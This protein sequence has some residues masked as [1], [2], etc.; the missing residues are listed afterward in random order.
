MAG[1]K[2]RAVNAEQKEQ[3]RL[4]ILESARS[5]F[6][7][8]TD[9]ASLVMKQIAENIGLT[10]GTLYLYFRTKE[11]VFLALYTQ[12]FNRLFDS[13]DEQI[14]QYIGNN[15]DDQERN[16][17]EIFLKIMTQCVMP[18]ETFLRLNALLH[19]VLEQNINSEPALEFKSMLRDRLNDAGTKVEMVLPFLHQGQGTELLFTTHELMIGCFHVALPT[20]C[21]EEIL[22]QPDM[23]FMK[24][25]F[26]TEF[27]KA[28]KLVLLG[29][30]S[31]NS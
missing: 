15:S 20:P 22:Q 17:I 2:S 6:I 13:I 19:T 29:Y 8:T 3:R 21:L 5:L 16:N 28:V 12:E 24:L 18:Q 11:E 23:A 30:E 26:E 1:I 9:Y 31:L 14:L 27:T 4:D 10:K 7:A 25:D